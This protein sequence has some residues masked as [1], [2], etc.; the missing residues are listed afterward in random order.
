M[1]SIAY[2]LDSG[3]DFQDRN[4]LRPGRDALRRVRHVPLTGRE[5]AARLSAQ[6]QRNDT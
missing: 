5:R 4:E 1:G 2:F 3:V 6:A